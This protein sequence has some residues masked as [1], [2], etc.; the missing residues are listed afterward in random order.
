M[1]ETNA[2]LKH[3]AYR[4]LLGAVAALLEATQIK[5]PRLFVNTRFAI[6]IFF[7]LF[8]A[9]FLCTQTLSLQKAEISTN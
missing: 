7:D 8:L 1:N 9:N 4:L 6:E 3:C 5:Q 2:Y